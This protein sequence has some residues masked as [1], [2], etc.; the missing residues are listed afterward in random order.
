[1]LRP[2]ERKAI[3]FLLTHLGFGVAGAVLVGGALLWFDMYGLWTLI[4]NYDQPVVALIL[5]FGGLIVTFGSVGMGIGIML[6]GDH[7]D[8]EP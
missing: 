8:K 4:R 5:L 2:F 7:S 6:E 1:M 3:Y